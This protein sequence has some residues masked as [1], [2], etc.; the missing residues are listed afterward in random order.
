VPSETE[1]R[2]AALLR[3]KL[4]A[5]VRDHAGG[6]PAVLSPFGGGAA[7]VHEGAAWVL[8]DDRPARALGPAL[9]WARQQGATTLNLLVDDEDAAG[10]LAR[11]ATYFSQPPGV[12]V[13][14]GRTLVP[15]VPARLAPPPPP[16]LPEAAT[17]L[18][19]LI[20]SAGAAPVIEH[21]VLTGEVGGLEVCRVVI[22][23][24]TGA[25][26][27]EVGVGA[28][29]REAFQLVHG[30]VPPVDALAGVVAAVAE[31]RRP[32]AAPHPLNRLGAERLLRSEL[33]D[34]PSRVGALF[35]AAAPP[36]VPRPNLKDAVPCV[37][38]GVDQDV[39][40]LVV[41]CSVGIDLDV[42]PFAADA[43][44]AT[45]RPDARLVIAIPPRDD[46]P[47]TRALSALLR[48][49]AEI[50]PVSF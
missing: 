7:L 11:R 4:G 10:V 34:D 16:P 30:N 19:P 5:L 15:A 26:R 44:A 32:G 27:L 3:M 35:V 23:P 31:H 1:Q 2:R 24:D 36:P 22:D 29:D 12:F 20:E 40:P 28:H 8:A 42:V 50:V 6:A 37:A 33:L 17:A 41:V 46:H 21:G 9:A 43:R 38:T 47:V 25:A 18:V 39:R 14:D 13:V 45:F 48:E 49:P